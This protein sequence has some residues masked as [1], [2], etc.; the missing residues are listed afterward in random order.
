MPILYKLAKDNRKASRTA[1]QFFARAIVTN[2]MDTEGLAEIMQR[3]CTVKKSDI[4]AVLTELVET[5]TDQL[6]NSTRVKL[7]GFGS[8]KIGIKGTG[9]Q[10]IDT[11]SVGKNVKGLRVNFSPEAKK[12]ATGTRTKKFL[13]NATVQEAPKNAIVG[14]KETAKAK[15]GGSPSA[16][17]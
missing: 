15:A 2:V 11:Y 3:N 6:Q 5:M 1:G 9:S 12:D 7:N 16:K 13:S 14:E 4:L 17:S 10:T 8:F